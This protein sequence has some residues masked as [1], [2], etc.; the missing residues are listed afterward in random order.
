MSFFLYFASIFGSKLC[1]HWH[2]TK[3]QQGVHPSPMDQ[4]DSEK[5]NGSDVSPQ[6][7]GSVPVALKMESRGGTT[8]DVEARQ[9]GW[10]REERVEARQ[11]GTTED[12][13]ARQEG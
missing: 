8:E 5:N 1:P 7:E 11:E 6:G 10:Q 4:P 12:V 9:E 2:G 13:E 3:K